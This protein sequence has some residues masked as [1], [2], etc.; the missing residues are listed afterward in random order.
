M[1][2]LDKLDSERKNSSK[3]KSKK[4]KK[5]KGKSKS[6]GSS[7]GGTSSSGGSSGTFSMDK[8]E[9]LDPS[10]KKMTDVAKE[11]AGDEGDLNYDADSGEGLQSYMNRQVRE[12]DELHENV[13]EM[14]TSNMG[15]FE[16]FTLYFHALF[17]NLA[18]NRVGVAETIHSE[19]GKSKRESLEIAN[20][21]CNRAGEKELMEELLQEMTANL[22]EV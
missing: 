1:V 9:L 3:N 5:K 10:D 4:K 16:Q 18:R 22:L 6:G 7:G 13:Q 17:F 2:D 8:D 20:K 21:V 15:D 11:W 14:A 12:V 19:F